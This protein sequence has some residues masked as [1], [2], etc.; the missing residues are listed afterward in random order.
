M[1]SKENFVFPSPLRSAFTTFVLSKT[2]KTMSEEYVD[3]F[4]SD[5]RPLSRSVPK[6]QAHQQGLW[7]R[8]A[9]VWI[10]D[11]TG[12]ILM[13]KR[14]QTKDTFPRLWDISVA[15]HISAGETP[16][17]GAL[18]ELKEEIGLE[19]QPDQLELLTVI[20][21]AYPY[22]RLGWFNREHC[23]VYLLESDAD[24]NTFTLQREEVEAVR[25]FTP[26]EFSHLTLGERGVA[27]PHED[28]YRQI[29]DAIVKKTES[30]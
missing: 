14:A 22:P 3:L 24:P 5:D 21:M 12:N 27:V 17:E 15:G 28:Y 7:H 20:H 4:D 1:P 23:Y 8:S 26:E 16:T 2:P 18:R 11:R 30:L 25:F 29:L 19:V 10:Y 6:R 9:H 13:Q